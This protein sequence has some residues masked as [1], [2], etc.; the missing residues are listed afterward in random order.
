[1]GLF[2]ALQSGMRAYAPLV[3]TTSEV[4]YSDDETNYTL[5]L[6]TLMQR[7]RR[8]SLVVVMTDFVDT[9]TAELM[10]DNLGRCSRGC[11][12]RSAPRSAG[13]AT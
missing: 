12:S 10:L 7:V 4:A 2:L 5:G 1:V 11:A 6:T 13:R 9:V 8:R 3:R